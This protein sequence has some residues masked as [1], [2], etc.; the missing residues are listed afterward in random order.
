M[1]RAPLAIAAFAAFAIVLE[2]SLSPAPAHAGGD[3][4]RADF[5]GVDSHGDAFVLRTPGGKTVLVDGAMRGAGGEVAE[6]LRRLGVRRIDLL[7]LSHDDPDHVG[8]LPAVARAFEVGAFWESAYGGS[9][10]GR[11]E[12]VEILAKVGVEPVAVSAGRRLELEDDVLL[13]VL[14]PAEPW[15]GGARSAEN[16]NSIVAR[17]THRKTRWLLT[18]DAE[19]ETEERLLAAGADLRCDVLKVAHHGS[20]TSSTKAFIESTR[21][22]VAVICC[23][24]DSPLGH[25][26]PEVLDRLAGAGMA[27]YRTDV[28]G[29]VTI[30]DA[31][32][33]P[34]GLRI[35]VERGEASDRT[36]NAVRP[37]EA[38]RRFAERSRGDPAPDGEGGEGGSGEP[39]PAAGLIGKVGR[40]AVHRP[41]CLVGSRIRPDDRVEW[42]SLAAARADGRT[43]C[44]VCRPDR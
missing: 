40:S 7:V 10:R 37:L 24:P 6:H 33:G 41:D 2:V 25:P 5:L 17:L 9:S 30:H 29:T 4:L 1:S 42:D 23:E 38:A 32:R 27:W 8:G 20:R 44:R 34:R 13:E 19:K 36:E 12:L 39:A 31:G 28:N 15:I 11:R 16:A 22:S 18:G 35:E 14:A 43:P 3:E 26:R 21:A